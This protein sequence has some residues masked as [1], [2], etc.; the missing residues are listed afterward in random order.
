MSPSIPNLPFV[1]IFVTCV[2]G[3]SHP[4]T[5]F[6]M[7]SLQVSQK[8]LESLSKN[9]ARG[10]PG[11]PSGIDI[12]SCEAKCQTDESITGC[13]MTE[14]VSRGAD[15]TNIVGLNTSPLRTIPPCD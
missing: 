13:T 14:G 2:D 9:G 15:G 7:P 10:S 12:G 1:M 11:K 4:R 6:S 8:S 3:A 5:L